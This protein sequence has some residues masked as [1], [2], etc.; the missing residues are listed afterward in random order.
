MVCSWTRILASSMS[1]K[2]QP[3][4][5]EA[6]CNA[7]ARERIFS[8]PIEHEYERWAK[9]SNSAPWATRSHCYNWLP[10]TSLHACSARLACHPL[11]RAIPEVPWLTIAPHAAHASHAARAAFVSRPLSP[12]PWLRTQL[13]SCGLHPPYLSP[14]LGTTATM[15]LS[16]FS[17]RCA[18]RRAAATAQPACIGWNEARQTLS[19]SW[20]WTSSRHPWLQQGGTTQANPCCHWAGLEQPTAMQGN[21]GRSDRLSP[22]KLF[23]IFP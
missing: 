11:V 12:A 13:H 16:L 23:E 4:L 1:L 5:P 22:R 7:L 6:A 9:F 10:C 3:I 8:E 14:K 15:S 2:H 17:A 20:S 19:L 18:M 21:S